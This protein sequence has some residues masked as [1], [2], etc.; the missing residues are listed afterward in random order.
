MAIGTTCT[1]DMKQQL[2]YADGWN[3]A[4]WAALGFGQRSSVQAFAWGNF[5]VVGFVATFDSSRWSE[6]G[7]SFDTDNNGWSTS[8]WSCVPRK[9]CVKLVVQE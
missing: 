5:F 6:G 7:A 3:G 2:A 9:G 4:E 1:L 8:T